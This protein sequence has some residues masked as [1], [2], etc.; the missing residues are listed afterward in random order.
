MELTKSPGMGYL[1]AT[2]EPLCYSFNHKLSP[3]EIKVAETHF[4]ARA[5][6][7]QKV[8]QVWKLYMRPIT[9]TDYDTPANSEESE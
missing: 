1:P 7:Q 8:G 4:N 2:M 3:Q 5:I 9:R 6:S